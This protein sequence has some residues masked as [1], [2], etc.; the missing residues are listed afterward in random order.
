M[1]K[2]LS[3]TPDRQIQA[4]LDLAE[5]IVLWTIALIAA[6]NLAL[7]FLPSLAR[8]VAPVWSIMTANT[9]V[10]LLLTAAG[11]SSSLR[12][13]SS[14]VLWLSRAAIAT[15]FILSIL[16]LW[17]YA[18]HV[19]F[20]IDRLLPCKDNLVYPGRPSP[21]TALAFVLISLSLFFLDK[22]HGKLSAL[23]DT[24]SLSLFGLL[25]VLLGGTLFDAQAVVGIN[26]LNRTAPQTLICLFCIAFV[27]ARRRAVNGR[28][29]SVLLH[30]GI[31]S[32]IMRV[33]LPGAVFVPFALFA[34]AGYIT[35]SS[36]IP[37]SYAYA[38]AASVGSFLLLCLIVW[39]AWRINAM[40]S[41]TARSITHKTSSR[42]STIDAASI[43]SPRRSTR[44][45]FAP[46]P[47]SP[48]FT[49]TSTASSRSMTPSATTPDRSSSATSPPSC[50]GIFAKATCW[51]A[52]EE[53]NSP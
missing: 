28:L 50:P 1:D 41:E 18:F 22:Q 17:E 16:T 7:W 19:S 30:I 26:P 51:A 29:F 23:A 31:G 14:L 52:S 43:C 45:R 21:Q 34:L 27:I 11:L 39:M 47:T 38:F 3:N 10:G 8:Y 46:A 37:L 24:L 25:F 42:L 12:A 32:R 20:G 36:A 2:D 4:G 35:R 53:T 15:L 49:S 13:R 44:T 40:E 9:A 33:M 48:S 6:T 5:R